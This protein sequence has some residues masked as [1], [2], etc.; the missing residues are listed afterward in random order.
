[1][2]NLPSEDGE[3]AVLGLRLARRGGQG[4]GED[5]EGEQE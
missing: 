3:F 4:G 2:V 5:R 1:M